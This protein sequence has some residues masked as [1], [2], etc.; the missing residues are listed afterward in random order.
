MELVTPGLGLIFWMTLS[1]A[2]L[3]YIL[4]RYAW[5]PIMKMIKEREDSIEDAL[6][7]A[8]KTKLEMAN[9]QVS[10]EKLL[11]EAKEER[12]LL[13]REA[14]KVKENII[15]EAKQKATSEAGIIIEN[16]RQ[17]I[18]NEKMAA[19]TELKNQIATLSI[20]IAEKVLSAE[21]SDKEKQN[22]FINK[23][24]NEVKLN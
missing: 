17:T 2:I 5:K 4:G 7:T 24:L 9:L 23:L 22:Q 19:I 16:A 21:L 20:E 12:E 11:K 3:L 8:E 14:R 6:Q 18:L 10:N 13:L 15:N 1:F